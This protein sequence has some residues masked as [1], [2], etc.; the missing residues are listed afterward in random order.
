MPAEPTTVTPKAMEHTLDALDRLS[1][2]VSHLVDWVGDHT[3]GQDHSRLEDVC[4]A[5]TSADDAI[6]DAK[7][8]MK[9]A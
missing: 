1:D 8:A 6:T 7:R 3:P 9:T 4:E 2:A 5:L